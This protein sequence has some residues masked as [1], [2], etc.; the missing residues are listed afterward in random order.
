MLLFTFS[1]LNATTPTKI[2]VTRLYLATFERSPDIEGLNYWLQTTLSLEE[3][4]M[5]FFDQDET[6]KKY[7]EGTTTKEFINAVYSHLFNRVPDSEGFDYWN[8]ELDEKTILQ[9]TFILA[10]I[11]GALDNDKKILEDKTNKALVLVSS[12]P[13]VVED[14]IKEEDT[15]VT[16]DVSTATT[17]AS[18]P[19]QSTEE[20]TTPPTNTPSTD[21]TL[22]D[23][24][25]S[26]DASAVS[27]DTLYSAIN[28]MDSSYLNGCK[29]TLSSIYQNGVV[30]DQFDRK[31]N[32]FI[33]LSTDNIPLH[34]GIDNG[35]YVF[36]SFMGEN[37]DSARYAIFGT[38]LSNFSLSLTDGT[39]QLFK[40]LMKK[41]SS[42]N[43]YD[44]S[45]TIATNSK[46][47]SDLEKW[48]SAKSITTNWTISDTISIS[49]GDF[50]IYVVNSETTSNYKIAQSRGKPVMLFGKPLPE[51]RDYFNVEY[52]KYAQTVGSW[53]SLD[54]ACEVQVEQQSDIQNSIL[55]FI[56]NIKDNNID[57]SYDSVSL[58][59]DVVAT[60]TKTNNSIQS[61]ILDGADNLRDI[62]KN[63]DRKDI[64]IFDSQRDEDKFI[65]L[66][67]LIGDKYR[68]D[69]SYPMDKEST[70]DITFFKAYYADASVSYARENNKYQPDLGDFSPH[71]SDLL[72]APISDETIT[73]TPNKFDSW[74]STGFYILPSQK[75]IVKRTDSSDNIIKIKFNIQR[76]NSTR[77]WEKDKYSRPRFVQSYEVD[78]D[79]GR[80]Y[81]L[82]S[83]YGG[84]IYV[85]W[86]GVESNQQPFT[87]EFKN[88]AKHPTLIVETSD[89]SGTKVNKYLSEIENTPFSW[90]D[91]KTPFLEI[92]TLVDYQ[93][94]A[95]T[96]EEEGYYNGD[97]QLYFDELKQYLVEDV[98]GVAGF[99]GDGLTLNSDVTAWC[100]T[101]SIDCS[102]Q[103]HQK[104]KI[105]HIISDYHS[106][107]GAA[108]SGN[109]FD[110]SEPLTIYGGAPVHEYGHNLQTT[111]LRFYSRYS[112]EVTN[113][114]FTQYVAYMYG[115]DKSREYA[116]Y[117]WTNYEKAYIAI[118]KAINENIPSEPNKHPLWL[119]VETHL[120]SDA[121][122]AFI[123]QI[124]F[125]NGGY[126]IWTKLYLL[127]RIFVDC[128]TSDSSWE[129]NKAKLGFS[130]YTQTEA[131]NLNIYTNLLGGNDF[132]SIVLSN[133]NKKDYRGL[134]D[135]WG[136]QLSDKAKAQIDTNGFD[137]VI[138]KAFY[139]FR[140]DRN[141]VLEE[142]T[143]TIP[144][145]GANLLLTNSITKI[146][147]SSGVENCTDG[148]LIYNFDSS[149]TFES[150]FT[151]DNGTLDNLTVKTKDNT[152][153]NLKTSTT[154][155]TLT[156]WIESSNNSS[157]SS[158]YK[159][160][161]Y[162]A[163]P[164][165]EVKNSSG[166]ATDR[167]KVRFDF[168]KIKSE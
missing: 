134:F 1:T 35:E 77:M 26:G 139:I 55:K 63:L 145:D 54:K 149:S 167:I 70:D 123:T 22:E 126:D 96:T 113:N 36:Y 127:D 48:L 27:L 57:I 140:D 44:E 51:H 153:I 6:K 99:Q 114:I 98:L 135:V 3:I 137:S 117:S 79:K 25:K 46:G 86:E 152:I 131:K 82:S 83:P 73:L 29:N 168:E 42:S 85:Y 5:S 102:S 19:T 32:R 60:N 120:D 109:P 9:S 150:I 56:N 110:M 108:T 58:Y 142:P 71:L 12:T 84:A 72:K 8:K 158:N 53:V 119:D 23:A 69:I 129:A 94:R 146:C 105:Q 88:V 116:N 163:V 138:P 41:E 104:P 93:K 64:N 165:I 76:I 24:L 118:S 66:A 31:T 157:L 14:I 161:A 156:I 122:Q 18:Q 159:K 52:T 128:L 13:L 34:G 80:E 68:Q 62:I 28:N 38:L 106:L 92:H 147:Q 17:Q 15:K 144:L 81:T 112:A 67:I 132:M 164:Y 97:I 133:I 136:L 43:I 2:N 111:L 49:D 91:I 59:G 130:N 61:D 141:L 124:R 115:K 50:D 37:R 162:D 103:I 107:A 87:L 7:P 78:L 166:K 121:R 16:E 125:L 4:A 148:A 40:W 45:L 101:N 154:N 39:T 21:T 47:K 90:T 89:F 95:Y 20:A 143:K 100:T 151:S 11:N 30:S 160:I 155:G 65:Q 75:I 74:T 33:S 10:I